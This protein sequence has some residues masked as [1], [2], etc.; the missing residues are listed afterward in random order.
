MPGNSPVI[1]AILDGWGVAPPSANNAVYQADTPNMDRWQK[2]CP[3]TTLVAHNG[4][5]GLP[6]GQMG[7]SEVGHLNIGAG[8]IVYQDYTRINL[9]IEEGDFANNPVITD[10]FDQVNKAGSTLHLCGLLSD[11]GVHSHINHLKALL[12][13]AAESQLDVRIHC[14]MD[15]RDT[16]PSSGLGFIQELA[17]ELEQNDSGKIAT[18]SGRYWAMD[19]DTRWNRVEKAWQA[20][21][22]GQGVTACDPVMAVKD[23]YDRDE[24]DEFIKPTVLLDADNL[25]VGLIKDGDAIFFFNFRADR[26]RELCHAFSD[27][28][29][30]GF[31]VTGRPALM[32]F[33]T[34][35]RYEADF[36]FPVAFPPLVLTHI[37]GQEVSQ[38]GMRQLRIAETEKYAHVTYFFNG[39]REE[40]FTGED[41][42]LIGS[43]REVATYDLKP[44]MSA[45]EVT[46]ALLAAL[47][48]KM[49]AGLPY[50]MVILNF[51]NGDMV[52]H[53]GV[54]EAAVAACETVDACLGR[55]SDF[56][57]EI[58]G[59]L[60][61]TA[62]HGNAEIMVNPET[63]E[64]FTSHTLSPV[65]LILVDKKHRQCT[66]A[67]GGALKDIAPTILALLGLE[68]PAE[69][70]GNSLLFCN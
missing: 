65:P 8:R 18:V 20:M 4:L 26:V 67:P 14:F 29:F 22:E 49:Q 12:A 48:K 25:P 34:M 9:A 56:L 2:D 45:V 15:G 13:M 70:E 10:I 30:S 37:L 39:G 41:R 24:T 27:P 6:E 32:E 66:L 60:L 68:K 62:D 63:G 46:E 43:P 64:P 38:A 33:A 59:I 31:P 57:Q 40:P 17:A 52:G 11:G 3:H 1:L 16:P 58:E 35:T 28:D 19:R 5:V 21:V 50:D 54:L 55:I 42:I 53:T 51:A 36:P 69:M 44:S 7:N 47:Q 23:A 61:V